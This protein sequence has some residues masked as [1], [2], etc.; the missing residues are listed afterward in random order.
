MTV[1]VLFSLQKNTA[2]TGRWLFAEYRKL[3]KWVRLSKKSIDKVCLS[4]II[5]KSRW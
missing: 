3:E 5:K 2:K 4:A 1:L